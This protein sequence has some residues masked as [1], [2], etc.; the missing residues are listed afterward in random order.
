MCVASVGFSS[1]FNGLVVFTI[2]GFM[3]KESGMEIQ[4]VAS[5]SGDTYCLKKVTKLTEQSVPRLSDLKVL[6]LFSC[7]TQ[8]SMEIFMLINLKMPTIVGILT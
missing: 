5:A 7:S 8:P 1:F 6:K 2:L 4:E 3:A